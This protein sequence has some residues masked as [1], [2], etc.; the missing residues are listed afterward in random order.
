MVVK[1]DPVLKAYKPEVGLTSTVQSRRRLLDRTTQASQPHLPHPQQPASASCARTP[2]SSSDC[3]THTPHPP[4]A[5][6]TTNTSTPPYRKHSPPPRRH[7]AL[8]ILS[9]LLSGERFWVPST[10]LNLTWSHPRALSCLTLTFSLMTF[11]FTN[12]IY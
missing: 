2:N 9:A 4:P 1:R 6:E 12:K 8:L 7:S 3:H 10:P 11:K 5:T